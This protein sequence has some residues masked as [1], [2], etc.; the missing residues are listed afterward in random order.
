M[1]SPI[2]GS[3]KD[4]IQSASR[5]G[6]IPDTQMTY[7]L[8]DFLAMANEELSAFALP[9]LHARREDYYIEEIN[10]SLDKVDFYPGSQ[11]PSHTRNPAWRIP[12]WAMASTIRDVQAISASGSFYY[13]GRINLDDI[14]ALVAQGWYFYGDYLVYNQN[15]LSAV[16]P[17]IAIR[18][19]VHVKPNRLITDDVF[20]SDYLAEGDQAA[21]DRPAMIL[22]VTDKT[23]NLD[24]VI[25][26]TPDVPMDITSG[27]PGYEVK[28]RNVVAVSGGGTQIELAETPTKTIQR[29]DWVNA[30]GW[31][32][33]VPLPLEMHPLLAQRL[34]VKFLEA[35]GDEQQ[36][37]Q[38]RASLEEMTRQVPLLIS[39]RAEGKPRKLTSRTGLWRRWRW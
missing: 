3:V 33:F 4:L 37:Q 30:A 31:T 19:L 9:I 7:V 28:L 6:N 13:L 21:I 15:N 14:P 27:S 17:P 2:L 38:A 39:P 32:S 12:T 34:V 35:Q 36:I 16:A 18:C 10:F 29:G 24:R 23:L 26:V 22:S 5:R 1:A 8:E 25:S 11:D 20:Y